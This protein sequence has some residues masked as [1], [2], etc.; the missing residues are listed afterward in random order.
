M[1]ALNTYVS[2]WEAPLGLCEVATREG[3][4]REAFR[5]LDELEARPSDVHHSGWPLSLKAAIY[6]HQDNFALAR[7]QI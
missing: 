1:L 7:D 2:C 3:K 5:I 6:A 4:L